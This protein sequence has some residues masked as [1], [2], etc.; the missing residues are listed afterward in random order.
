MANGI[1][2]YERAF[3]ILG[4]QSLKEPL[5]TG[6]IYPFMNDVNRILFP[7]YASTQYESLFVGNFAERVKSFDL[8]Q[9]K[10]G[11]WNPLGIQRATETHR[12]YCTLG[13]TMH[14]LE[15]LLRAPNA[16][17][18]TLYYLTLC[19]DMH[20][21]LMIYIEDD[22][23]RATDDHLLTDY[24][25]G[26]PILT[27]E[28]RLSHVFHQGNLPDVLHYIMDCSFFS[29]SRSK[30]NPIVHLLSKSLPQRCT[31]RNL[32]EIVSNYCRKYDDVY[33]FVIGCLKCSLLGLYETSTGRPPLSV[34]VRL[35]RKFNSVS[36]GAMLQW[37]LSNHQ[38]LLFYIIKEFLVYGVQQIPS[39][40]DEV[41]ERYQWEKFEEC[42][43][44]AMNRVRMCVANE[45]NIMDFHGVEE[46]LTYINK[47]Q[48]SNLYRPTRHPFCHVVV[49]ECDK[50]DDANFVDFVTK[51]L[52]VEHADLMYDMA[53]RYECTHKIPYQWLSYFNV[54]ART[55]KNIER[56]QSIYLTEGS[57]GNLKSILTSLDRRDFE[58]IRKFSEVFDRKLNIRL[59]T[60]PASMYI[61]QTIALRRKHHIPDGVELPEGVGETLVCLQCK[62]FKPFVISKDDKGKVS[63][64]YAFGHSKVLVDDTTM[65]LYCGKRCDKVDAKKRQSYTTEYS[66]FM[67]IS[68]DIIEQHNADRHR[69]RTAKD[70]RK[71][72][73]NN[74]CAQT[75]LTKINMLGKLLQFYNNLYIICPMCANFMQ[76]TSEYFTQEGMYCGCCIQHGRLYTEVTCEWC[77]ASR[78]NETWTPVRVLDD[79]VDVEDDIPTDYTE[80]SIYLCQGCHKPWIRNASVVLKLSTVLKGLAE[81][82]KRL[83]HA[84]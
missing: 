84:Q 41:K 79:T 35:I 3:F 32:R 46:Q 59:F 80:R 27:H 11:G 43:N 29:D 30:G 52:S 76:V 6:Q 36:K 77:L 49:Q 25:D 14:A 4:A 45:E 54:P 16:T 63:N 12:I 83:Q 7:D 1:S 67:Q 64:L 18:Q 66:S 31:I 82:W 40:Y 51:E 20:I 61:Q 17:P 56:I 21:P 81:K 10:S 44:I 23:A 73:K 47:Q 33:D 57:K 69:K 74:L 15:Q 71:I 60:M 38:Q 50:I 37:M 19:V 58:A 65:K 26:A 24:G 55:I 78:G 72:I 22:T 75:E 70:A 28:P 68:D 8:S 48:V 9:W 5:V 62:Q 53:I 2:R 13:W 39:L 34:R 42:V